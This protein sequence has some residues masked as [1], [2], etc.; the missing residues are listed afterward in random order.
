VGGSAP[1]LE[2]GRLKWWAV[3]FVMLIIQAQA[4]ERRNW[5]AIRAW[6]ARLPVALQIQVTEEM[7]N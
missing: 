3:L 5:D 2:Y 4:G 1:R 6:A 7:R